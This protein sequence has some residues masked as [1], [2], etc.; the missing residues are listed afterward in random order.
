MQSKVFEANGKRYD[1]I[2]ASA[3]KQE[4]LL[5]LIGQKLMVAQTISKQNEAKLNEKSLALVLMTLPVDLKTKV[6]SILTEKVFEIGSTA[7]I[8]V[9]IKDFEGRIAQWYLFLAQLLIW[10]LSDFFEFLQSV[11]DEL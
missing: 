5:S 10:N 8:P 3:V 4:E 9:S 7:Q 1:A 11:G 2:M 6:A